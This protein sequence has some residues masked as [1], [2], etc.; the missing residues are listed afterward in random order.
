[1]LTDRQR[2]EKER[3]RE[4]EYNQLL[5]EITS[6]VQ[7]SMEASEHPGYKFYRK[8]LEKKNSRI[9]EQIE[10][11]EIKNGYLSRLMETVMTCQSS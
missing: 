9:Q 10:R 6:A 2:E 8:I 11:L 1:M 5:G 4:M 7:L 3:R